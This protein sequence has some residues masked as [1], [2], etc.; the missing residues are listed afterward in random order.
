MTCDTQFS[1]WIPVVHNKM[2]YSRVVINCA[3]TRLCLLIQR[4][5]CAVYGYA[6]KAD[7]SKG[8]WNLTRKLAI[9]THFSK[10]K[11]V[12]IWKKRNL[13]H[14]YVFYSCLVVS[15]ICIVINNIFWIPKALPETY[16]S[17]SYTMN[18]AKTLVYISREH[19]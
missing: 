13:I 7:L 1:F 18:F 9:N 6:G 4:Y 14:R 3:K 19:P 15:P 10:I 8:Y 17:C 16:F 5:F 2:S 12:S 11:Y